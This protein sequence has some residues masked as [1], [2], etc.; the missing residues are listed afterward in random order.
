MILIAKQLIRIAKL[1]LSDR[2]H[3]DRTTDFF[4]SLIKYKVVH[5]KQIYKDKEEYFYTFDQMHGHWQIF[6]KHKKHEG[7]CDVNGNPLSKAIKGR[8]IDL[9]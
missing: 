5:N 1:I 4:K 6:N 8:K 2:C 7:T 3:I 9:D